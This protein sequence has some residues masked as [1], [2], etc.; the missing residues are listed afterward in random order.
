MKIALAYDHT[1]FQLANEI[2]I[3]IQK[4]SHEVINFGPTSY[5]PAD[6]YPDYIVPAAKAV[7]S[8]QCHAGIIFGGSGQGEAMAANR[9][10]GVRCIVFYGSIKPIGKVDIEG[11]ISHNEYEILELSKQHNLAN[12]LSLADRFL[13]LDEMKKAI[14]IWLNT[15]LGNDERHIRRV[16]KLDNQT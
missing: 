15:P 16:N 14:E 12:V 7:A 10:K 1:G 13:S 9:I 8:G 11:K 3:F 6:D 5:N 2:T 4:L